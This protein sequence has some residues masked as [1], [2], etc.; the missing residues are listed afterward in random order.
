MKANP[1]LMALLTFNNVATRLA[2]HFNKVKELDEETL[3]SNI[4]N[5]LSLSIQIE[6][7]KELRSSTIAQ[8]A[9]ARLEKA[10]TL[11]LA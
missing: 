2:A 8:G 6:S 1:K 3:Y 5:Y 9:I 11:K 7:D 4:Q 10:I